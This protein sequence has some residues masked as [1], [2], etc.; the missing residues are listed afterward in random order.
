MAVTHGPQSTQAPYLQHKGEVA[1]CRVLVP[2]PGIEPTPPALQGRFVT[3]GPPGRSLEWK[4]SYRRFLGAGPARG[5]HPSYLHFPL[6]GSQS[7]DPH[8]TAAEAE[9]FGVVG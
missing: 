1:A 3:T 7:R 8:L 5:I 6:V 4:V 2:R 9:K